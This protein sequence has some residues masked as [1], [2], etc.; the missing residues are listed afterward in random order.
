MQRL[1][2]E[3]THT[4]TRTTTTVCPPGSGTGQNYSPPPGQRPRWTLS[5]WLGWI[6]PGHLIGCE[7]PGWGWYYGW[8]QEEG[9]FYLEQEAR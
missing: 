2:P 5:D 8:G 9:A 1:Q 4:R 6:A 7:D 3:L